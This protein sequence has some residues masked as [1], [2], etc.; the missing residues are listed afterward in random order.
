MGG[1]GGGVGGF[2]GVCAQ[3]PLLPFCRSRLWMSRAEGLP[4]CPGG[5]VWMWLVSPL[6]WPGWHAGELPAPNGLGPNFEALAT[7]V[8]APSIPI[9]I[10]DAMINRFIV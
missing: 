6:P 9:D 2:G 1:A 10:A 3:L 4:G 7:P 5:P 8:A